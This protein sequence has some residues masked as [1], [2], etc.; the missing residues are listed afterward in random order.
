MQRKSILYLATFSI[1]AAGIAC[2]R[3]DQAQP[4]QPQDP[5]R[6]PP[7]ATWVP[8]PP[9]P[10]GDPGELPG[11]SSLRELI[12]YANLMQPI[13]TLAGTVLERDGL[14]L[15]EAE[16]GNDTVLCDGRLRSDNV[17]M[18]DLVAQLQVINAPNDALAIHDLVIQSGSAW[19]EA[20]D[21][22]ERFCDTNNPLFKVSAAVKL[23]EAGVALQDAGNRFWLLLMAE[24]V[25]DWV[26][27]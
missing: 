8:I 22:V 18:K 19:T 24:G 6:L 4:A 16:G 3:G 17:S 10:V 11:D 14:I 15:K 20:L 2:G 7:T 13:L 9:P 26:Q 1:L 21:E 25:E 12:T 23:W 27:R 5:T